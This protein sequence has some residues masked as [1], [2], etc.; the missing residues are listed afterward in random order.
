MYPV[1]TENKQAN[2][3]IGLA[4]TYASKDRN[5]PRKLQ[6]SERAMVVATEVFNDANRAFNEGAHP[7]QLPPFHGG[8]DAGGGMDNTLR[9]KIFVG[10]TRTPKEL[11]VNL[12]RAQALV[13]AANHA[14]GKAKF[15]A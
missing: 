9:N 10:E 1:Q 6:W 8:S 5:D 7:L 13:A 12:A 3:N 4:A 2:S 14:M 15:L 11:E